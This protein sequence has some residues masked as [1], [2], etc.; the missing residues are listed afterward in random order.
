MNPPTAE[1]RSH[2]MEMFGDER[3]DDYFWLN[4]REDKDVLD[5]L[6]KENDYLENTF[7]K[8]GLRKELYNEIISR[9]KKDDDSVPYLKRGYYHQTTYSGDSEYP[10][11]KRRKEGS[12][13]YEVVLDVNKLAEGET[14]C[15]VAGVSYDPSNT[16][17]A[18]G[19]DSVGRRKYTIRFRNLTNGVECKDR[20]ENTT[21]RFVFGHNH[22][23]GYYTVK[24]ETTLRSH[25]IMMHKLGES[26]ECDVCI[27]HE[28]D[29]KYRIGVYKTLDDRFLIIGSHAN[30]TSEYRV[31]DLSG[32]NKEWRL[33]AERREGIEYSVDY[34]PLRNRFLV[35]TNWNAKNFRIMEVPIDNLGWENMVELVPTRDHALLESTDVFKNYLILQERSNGQVKLCVTNLTTDSSH[36]MDF[37]EEIYDVWMS[38]NYVYDT[39]ILRIGYGSLTTPSSTFDYNMETRELVLLKE[40]EVPNFD[41]TNYESKKVMTK[42][43]DGKDLAISM[44]Y[45]KDNDLNNV[46][47][48]IYGYGSYGHTIDPYLSLW[49]VSLLDRG[50][51]FAIAHIRGSEY[52]GRKWYDDGKMLNKMNTFRDFV[53]CSEKLINDGYTTPNK[54]FAMGGSAG[55]LLMGSVTNMRPDLYRGIVSMVPFVDVLTTMLDDTI[56]LTVGEYD[57]WGNPN[58]EEYYRYIKSYSPYDNIE[59]KEYPNILLTT[60]LHDSQVQYWEP[61]KY[62]AKMR[63]MKTDDNELFLYTDMTSGHGGASGRF[64]AWE[65]MA[66]VIAFILRYA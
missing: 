30:I 4:Q 66:L 8:D 61:A 13:D 42:T 39:N 60:G 44:V 58:E 16:I 29:E 59:R 38:S 62:T 19:V 32:P 7:P 46:P 14:F 54:L 12:D 3:V 21:G 28:E 15:Q 36:Y 20:L 23:Y 37:N 17:M 63:E 9:I 31:S 47:F 33:I 43:Y 22:T 45:R 40:K 49:R 41:K 6:T 27:H 57:E 48:L 34:D 56:P 18:Y 11:Y 55:G 35:L 53:T 25:K 52:Y 64:K 10:V 26:Q 51:G 50:F 24:D 2:V 65:E 1:K 5:Y